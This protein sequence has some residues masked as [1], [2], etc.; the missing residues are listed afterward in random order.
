MARA[1]KFKNDENFKFICE[2]TPAGNV[3]P[4][5]IFHLF[6]AWFI[7]DNGFD[8]ID[9]LIGETL[10]GAINSFIYGGEGAPISELAKLI[11][12]VTGCDR[13]TDEILKAFLSLRIFGDGDCPECGGDLEIDLDRPYRKDPGDYY[14]PGGIYEAWFTCNHCGHSEYLENVNC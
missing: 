7:K 13:I 4:E 14:T 10:E 8:A 2:N 11:F 3:A 6:N 5:S 1:I 12:S 9:D